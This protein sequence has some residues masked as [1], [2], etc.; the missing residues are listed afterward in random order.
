[1]NQTNQNEI[2]KTKSNI[3]ILIFSLEIDEMRSN[4]NFAIVLKIEFAIRI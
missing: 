4:W 1:M 2:I 3:K